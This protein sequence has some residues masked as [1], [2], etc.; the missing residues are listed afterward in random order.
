M[1]IQKRSDRGKG[2]NSQIVRIET[3]PKHSCRVFFR[4]GF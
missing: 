3:L 2:E 1:G 4:E